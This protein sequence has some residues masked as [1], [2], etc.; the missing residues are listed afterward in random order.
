MT[1]NVPQYAGVVVYSL[2][3]M[4]LGFGITAKST[5]ACKDLEPMTIIVFN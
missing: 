4:P 5:L 3:D 1:E 2:N